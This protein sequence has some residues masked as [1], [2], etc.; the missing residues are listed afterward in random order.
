VSVLNVKLKTFFESDKR[1]LMRER[2][3]ALART[4]AASDVVTSLLEQ[5]IQR[6]RPV[7]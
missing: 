5:P 3:L 4:Q 7:S 6:L 2:A 1:V